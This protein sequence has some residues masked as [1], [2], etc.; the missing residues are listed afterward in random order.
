MKQKLM[1]V[2]YHDPFEYRFMLGDID[3]LEELDPSRK[4]ELWY[5]KGIDKWV[6]HVE[7]RSDNE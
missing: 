4:Y 2:G 1:L 6:C 7:L 5:D 3:W